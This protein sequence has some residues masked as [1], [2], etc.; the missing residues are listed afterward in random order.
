MMDDE[1]NTKDMLP[2]L[3]RGMQECRLG[4][5]RPQGGRK[6]LLYE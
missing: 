4:L 3:Q 1:L 2:T 5:E 6:C